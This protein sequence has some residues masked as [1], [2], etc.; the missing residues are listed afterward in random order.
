MAKS[1][2]N[3][4]KSFKNLKKMWK[5]AEVRS[6]SFEELPD[7]SYVG[8]VIEASISATKEKKLPNVK[9]VLEVVEGDYEGRKVFINHVLSLDNEEALERQLSQLKTTLSLWYDDED[10]L[11]TLGEMLFSK[12]E[13]VR[14][15]NSE[16]W[17]SPDFEKELEKLVNSELEFKVKRSQKKDENGEVI[18]GQFYVNVYLNE[19]LNSTVEN[20]GDEDEGRGGDTP[21]T[22]EEDEDDLEEIEEDFDE[23]DFDDE[24]E[25]ED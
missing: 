5:K 6:G 20:E 25:D 9:L 11:D 10:K 12:L 8:K 1:F 2:G 16:T 21:E 13:K 15:G 3:A 19:L 22:Y 7:G 23:E 4:V 18:P 14:T 24:D 17:T